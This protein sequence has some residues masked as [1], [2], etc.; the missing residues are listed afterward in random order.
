MEQKGSGRQREEG[1]ESNRKWIE[2][3]EERRDTQK[4]A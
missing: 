3:K 1:P 4:E 2:G